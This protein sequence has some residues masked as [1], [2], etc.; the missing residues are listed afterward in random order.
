MRDTEL[1]EQYLNGQLKPDDHLLAE[2]K[3]LVNPELKEK[4]V[5]QKMTYGLVKKYGRKKLREEIQ[6]TENL[7]FNDPEFAAFRK[8]I[9][10]IFN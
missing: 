1:I 9:H 7:L 2:A 8:K 3:M 4:T 5:W 10:S 6:Q